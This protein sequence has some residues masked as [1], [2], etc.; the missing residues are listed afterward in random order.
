MPHQR[1]DAGKEAEPMSYL[2]PINTADSTLDRYE[3]ARFPSVQSDDDDDAREQDECRPFHG[4]FK[5]A[6]GELRSE[7][8]EMREFR[9]AERGER[10]D[11]DERLERD[12]RDE[13]L[14]RADR[15]DRDDRGGREI[16][17]EREPRRSL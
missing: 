8:A 5:S 17:L 6:Y 9:Q 3:P 12:D 7:V 13:R 14:E 4:G 15:D 11:R 2:F 10:C 16:E 1:A